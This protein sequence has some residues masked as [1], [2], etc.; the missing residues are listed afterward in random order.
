MMQKLFISQPMKGKTEEEIKREREDALKFAK[1]VLQ[2]DVELIDSYIAENP[3]KNADMALWCLGRS[4]AMMSEADIVCFAKGCKIEHACAVAYG[5]PY[6][7]DC[8]EEME[9]SIPGVETE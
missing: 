4:L 5:K 8:G 9:I 7:A 6:F 2:E 1:E 3:P